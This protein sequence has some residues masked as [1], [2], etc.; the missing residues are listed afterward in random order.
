MLAFGSGVGRAGT[1]PV[2][3]SLPPM[4]RVQVERG[5]TAPAVP[6][7]PAVARFEPAPLPNEDFAAPRGP[8]GATG[9]V[10]GAGIIRQTQGYRGDGFVQGSAP[11]QSE[12]PRRMP[13]PSITLKVPLN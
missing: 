8:G 4:A 2:D 1:V 13:L 12:Q 5:L 7:A 9:P 10:L 6:V 11:P 3:A